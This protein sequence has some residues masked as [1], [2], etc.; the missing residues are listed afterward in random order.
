MLAFY[1]KIFRIRQLNGR[2]SP[3]KKNKILRK[4][5]NS[6]SLLACESFHEA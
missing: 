3:T 5:W 6:E 2:N 1:F 4:N